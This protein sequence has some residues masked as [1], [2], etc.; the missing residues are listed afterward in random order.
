[1]LLN[2]FFIGCDVKPL[3]HSHFADPSQEYKQYFSSS[4]KNTAGHRLY[5]R[6]SPSLGSDPGNRGLL[7][8]C[9]GVRKFGMELLSCPAWLLRH[10]SRLTDTQASKPRLALL[11][12]ACCRTQSWLLG[13]VTVS[14]SPKRRVSSTINSRSVGAV[15]WPFHSR[16]TLEFS[17]HG[18]YVE[19]CLLIN[20]TCAEPIVN[21]SVWND[22]FSC[23]VSKL[24]SF[25]KII[26]C[27]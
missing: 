21:L 19:E 16:Y 12:D 20:Y 27:H 8:V 4:D 26:S 25:L 14:E 10:H 7:C 6:H 18:V 9:A 1:M 13:H 3:S 17:H 5:S 2:V 23:P 24:W 11:Q 22:L 15:L